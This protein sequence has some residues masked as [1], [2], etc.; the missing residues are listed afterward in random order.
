MTVFTFF[1]LFMLYL[2]KHKKYLWL[3]IYFTLIYVGILSF[4]YYIFA[5]ELRVEGG[6][7]K[8]KI[9]AYWV[10]FASCLWLI[11]PVV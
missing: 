8:S 2:Q 10:G 7:F 9:S 11:F 3:D 1:W 5:D 4:L 6:K